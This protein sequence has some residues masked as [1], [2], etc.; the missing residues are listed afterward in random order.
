MFKLYIFYFYLLFTHDLCVK[1]NFN[2]SAF[3]VFFGMNGMFC[4]YVIVQYFPS[5][6]SLRHCCKYCCLY[7]CCV[8]KVVHFQ[9]V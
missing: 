5:L 3:L 9:S 2:I 8:H 7:V 1:C 4:G 6:K